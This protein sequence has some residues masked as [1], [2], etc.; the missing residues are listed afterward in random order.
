MSDAM[1]AVVR[2]P[3]HSVCVVRTAE[4]WCVIWRGWTW[5]HA[6]RQAALA[7]AHAIAAAHG[8]RVIER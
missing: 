4:G 8:V 6:T 1:T 7:D 5:R 2:F 3:V